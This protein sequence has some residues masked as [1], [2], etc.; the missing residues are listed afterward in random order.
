V[1]ELFTQIV[2]RTE[3]GET[4]ALC[5]VVR[6]RGSTPRGKG[7]AM[8]VLRDGNSIGTL[9]GGCVEAEVRVRA[10][11]L[12][13]ANQNR[14][15]SFSLN[16]DF[17]WD[18]GLV[19][20]GVMEI[21]IQIL[22]PDT[23]VEAIKRALTE[24]A[25]YR[26]ATL[27]ID[28][29]DESHQSAQFEIQIPPTPT[30]LIAGAGHVGRSLALIARQIDFRVVVVDDRPDC[31][32]PT[33]TTGAECILGDIEVQ[34]SEFDINPWTY[35]V[36]VTRGHRHDAQALAAVVRSPAAYVGLI[37]S[38]RKI[39]TILNELHAQGVSRECL[40]KVHAPIGLEIAA[41]T[42]AEIAVSIAAELIAV[43]RGRGDLPAHPMKVPTEKLER[44]LT[45]SKPEE[46]LGTLSAR[47]TES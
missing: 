36:I 25:A 6:T 14:L 21:A 10:Q 8:L 2:Q 5:T 31:L 26:P 7:A 35:V 20:G 13:G 4:V 15:L 17:G 38:K 27:A 40:A 34:L 24:L 44:W 43:R 42:P 46:P 33:N 22:S 29:I 16:Q 1:I 12:M 41:V 18:D 39:H 11:Q 28:V 19:C 9:G 37:G 30:L 32:A 45:K 3:I 47:Q 23:S